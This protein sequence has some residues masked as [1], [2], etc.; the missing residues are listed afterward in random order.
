MFGKGSKLGAR[1]TR[2]SQGLLI[3]LATVG[4]AGVQAASAQAATRTTANLIKN[5]GAEAG[6]GGT[7]DPV[8]LP[9]WTRVQGSTATA[10]KYGTPSFPTLSSPGPTGRGKNF[11][12]GG[13][14]DSCGCTQH[15]L[16]QNISLQRFV[17]SIK[18]GHVGY[19]LFGSFGGFETQ[20][21][22]AGLELDWF[23]TN[24]SF[25][26]SQTI[27]FFLAADRKNV[28]GMLGTGVGAPVPKA[29]RSARVTIVFD[30][31]A[32]SYN[33]GYADNLSLVL[34]GV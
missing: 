17:S 30:R 26:G 24:G 19:Q 29:A 11:F 12:A 2:L 22:T 1:T 25:I 16:V 13:D 7:G 6:P 31:S 14:P 20:N 34:Q 27:G 3:A 8:S 15:E 18:R 21:D 32:G 23:G 28:T 9:S 33:D 4:L 10:V 5:P